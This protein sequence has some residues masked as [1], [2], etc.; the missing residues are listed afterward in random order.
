[1]VWKHSGDHRQSISSEIASYNC[2]L[3]LYLLFATTKD[4][5]FLAAPG[6]QDSGCHCSLGPVGFACFQG[7]AFF[8]FSEGCGAGSGVSTTL[9]TSSFSSGSVLGAYPP[10]SFGSVAGA[11]CSRGLSRN[12]GLLA[13]LSSAFCARYFNCAC[14]AISPCCSCMLGA[15]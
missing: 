7:S 8:V 11:G 4:Y 12:E 5:L 6:V 13:H 15:S 9:L 14:L 1:M 10:G 3:C 2:G